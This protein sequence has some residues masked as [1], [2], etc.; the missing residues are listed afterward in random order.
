MALKFNAASQAFRTATAP[1]HNAAYT[2][3][4]WGRLD[5]DTNNFS[6][7]LHI[8]GNKD[9]SDGNTDFI[10]TAS[11]GTT[12][13]WACT[14]GA[15]DSVG[16]GAAVA[17]GSYAWYALVRESATSLKV[18]RGTN[19]TDGAL[20]AT[21]TNDVSAR[22]AA[23]S[24]AFGSYNGF[25]IDGAIA[26]PRIWTRAL[27]LAQ[28]HAEL[29]SATVVDATNLWSSPPFSGASV[30][31]GLIDDSGNSR[32]FSSTGTVVLTSDPS[33]TPSAGETIVGIF[34]KDA[35]PDGS[36]DATA[37][38][39]GW[40]DQDALD[41]QT[42]AAGSIT[43]SLSL[44]DANDAAVSASS[45]TA[46][47]SLVRA[48]DKDTLTAAGTTSA[49]ELS[50][51]LA[52]TDGADAA[53]SAGSLVLAAALAAADGADMSAAA[54]TAQ[55]AGALSRTDAQDI[56][57]GAAA[58]ELAASAV[59]ADANDTLAASAE[60]GVGALVGALALTDANDAAIASGALPTVA[61]LALADE[62][63]ALAASGSLTAVGDI[64]A[65]CNLTDGDDALSS[66]AV[67]GTIVDPP[68][69]R[70]GGGG[71]RRTRPS[72]VDSL[73][74]R[75]EPRRLAVLRPSL[76]AA[77]ADDTVRAEA[78]IPWPDR[79]AGA[80]I[81]DGDD[82]VLAAGSIYPFV[83][84]RGLL[85]DARLRRPALKR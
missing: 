84:V 62:G 52:L 1:N 16:T 79:A 40:F 85:R 4:C 35:A 59:L 32:D 11:D 8:G 66:A 65:Q 29:A 18:Y 21:L 22:A 60:L 47:A 77:D 63:D 30:A 82:T 36:F 71:G 13:R 61:V 2:I 67:I 37:R 50:A 10:G 81:S 53:Q 45:L 20:V 41:E 33:F 83:L 75:P 80:M 34:N 17:I 64:I 70:G 19:S 23:S 74:L 49:A 15:T 72:F 24:V 56:A 48:D 9:F 25:G 28:L 42:A 51:A 38:A 55:V 69:V 78:F 14:G 58:S 73:E 26:K 12:L 44:A 7:F 39:L 31:A 46:S 68:I 5:A 6:H 43:G 76:V 3:L 54:A 57:S 27:T